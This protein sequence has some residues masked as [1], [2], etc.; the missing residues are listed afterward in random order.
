MEGK[1]LYGTE[2]F[3]KARNWLKKTEDLFVIIEVEDSRKV[4]LAACLLK[5]EA[6]F[7]WEVTQADRPVET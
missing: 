4:Q 7:W 1:P 2:M 3:L 6:S 5:N